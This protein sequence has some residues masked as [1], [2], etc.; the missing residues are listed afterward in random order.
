MA[1]IVGIALVDAEEVEVISIFV[2][3]SAIMTRSAVGEACIFSSR[4]HSIYSWYEDP[5]KLNAIATGDEK[6]LLGLFDTGYYYEVIMQVQTR[7]VLVWAMGCGSNA[8][9]KALEW[10]FWFKTTSGNQV[11]RQ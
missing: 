9:G 10:P 2:G 11:D 4:R 7:K 3:E 1:D 5:P 6:Q 8:T